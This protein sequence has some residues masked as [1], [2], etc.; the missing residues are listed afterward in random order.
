MRVVGGMSC[1]EDAPCRQVKQA[2]AEGA[3]C[4]SAFFVQNHRDTFVA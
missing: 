4:L 2:V 3:R 1:S